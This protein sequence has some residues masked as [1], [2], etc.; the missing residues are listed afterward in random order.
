MFCRT[1]GSQIPDNYTYCPV[2]GAPTNQVPMNQNGVM[3]NYQTPINQG[4]VPQKTNKGLTIG[5]IISCVIIIVLL[6]I[7]IV[8]KKDSRKDSSSSDNTTEASSLNDTTDTPVTTETTTEAT[9]EA[10]QTTE[11][12][13]ETTTE[14]T[15]EDTTEENIEV[16]VDPAIAKQMALQLLYELQ[17]QSDYCSDDSCKAQGIFMDLNNDGITELL[18]TYLVSEDG[19]LYKSNYKL[20]TLPPEGAV[21]LKEDMIYAHIGENCGSVGVAQKDGTYYFYE[22]FD[23]PEYGAN[24]ISTTFIP[25]GN[26][27]SLI[28]DNQT[29]I[30]LSSVPGDEANGMYHLNDENITMDE[31][32]SI[33]GS[34]TKTIIIDTTQ[35]PSDT[36]IIYIHNF[37]TYLQ[38]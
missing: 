35:A 13:T 20:W 8:P 31:Y 37:I 27:S 14:S 16:A 24:H 15:T 22:E 1:C 5:L 11:A 19:V 29:D 10:E 7:I 17:T 32:N 6:V 9:T 3:P 26:G 4:N 34:F 2:C 25:F 38:Q 30:D 21:L 12:T 33:Y 28:I 23:H 18:I 36:N